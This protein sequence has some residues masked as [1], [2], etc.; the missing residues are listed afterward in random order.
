MR[1]PRA[2]PAGRLDH[3]HRSTYPFAGPYHQEFRPCSRRYQFSENVRRYPAQWQLPGCGTRF[4]LLAVMTHSPLIS[5]ALITL[6]G[7]CG[8]SA[9]TGTPDA[10]IAAD[11]A[12]SANRSFEHPFYEDPADCPDDPLFN[13]TADLELCGDGRAVMLVTDIVNDGTYTEADGVIVTEWD[14]GD[15][16]ARIAFSIESATLLTDDWNG[17]SWTAVSREFSFCE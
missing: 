5:L 12:L 9:V 4:A 17:W 6:C 7:A 15:I 10:G 3:D 13:C 14:G 1:P 11:A 8:G 2:S 16:P